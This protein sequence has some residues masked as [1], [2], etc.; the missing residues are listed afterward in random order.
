M[1]PIL[2]IR[3]FLAAGGSLSL[4]LVTIAAL[5]CLQVGAFVSLR[6]KGNSCCLSFGRHLSLAAADSQEPSM[7]SSVRFLGRG[8]RAIVRP[9]VLLVAPSNEF[10]HFYRQAAIF[11][12]AMGEDDDGVYVVRGVIID[13]PTPFTLKE[14]MEDNPAVQENPLADNLLFRGGDK[15]GDGVILLHNQETL[16]QSSVGV[17]GIFQGGW[18]DALQACKEGRAKMEDFKVFFNYCE[19]TEREIDDLL[20]SN[21]DGDQWMSVEVDTDFILNADW[22]R[23]DAWARIRNALSQT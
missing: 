10:H 1:K 17:S 5:S 4:F 22:G 13:H 16:G 18:D 19:F 3:S 9:G 8:Q 7:S 2:S 12:H 11:I 21:E 15:G 6:H 14:M 23:G 20:E